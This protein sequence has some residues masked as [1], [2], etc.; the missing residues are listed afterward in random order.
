MKVQFV[1]HFTSYPERMDAFHHQMFHGITHRSSPG[2]NLSTSHDYGED[3]SDPIFYTCNGYKLPDFANPI[4]TYIISQNVM[5][6]IK[7]LP[8]LQFGNVIPKKSFISHTRP[9][10]FP[11]MNGLIS[12]VTPINFSMIKFLNFGRTDLN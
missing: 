2:N 1:R 9:G 11:I 5:E 3:L 7:E 10:I 8:G 4:G 6:L 12:R